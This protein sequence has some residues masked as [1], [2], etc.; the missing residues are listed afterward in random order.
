MIFIE[1]IILLLLLHQQH[2]ALTSGYTLL[3]HHNPPDHSLLTDKAALLAFKKTIIHDPNS[4]LDNWDEAVDVC[5]FTKVRCDKHHHHVVRLI[6]NE[7][8]LVGLL[9][10]FLSNLTRLR[11]LVFIGNHLFG[12]IPPEFS[13]LRHLQLLRIEGNNLQGTIPESLAL[14]SQL[15]TL[16]IKQNNISGTI[17]PSIFSNCTMLGNIDFSNNNLTGNIPEEIGNCRVLWNLNLY[18]NKFTGQLPFSLTN[19]SSFMYNIDVENNLLTGELPSKIVGKLPGLELLHLS[20]NWMESTN[21][22]P[23]FIALRNCTSLV[24]LELAGMH[25]GG[26]FPIS[27]GQLSTYLETLLLQENQLFGSIP[28]NVANLSNLLVLNLTSNLLNGT[29]PAEISQLSSLQQLFLSHNLFTSEIPTALGKF[30]HL[31][32]LDLSHNKFS[33]EIPAILGN[34]VQINYLFLN[35]NLLSGMIPPTLGHCTDLN[36]L[37]LSYNRLTGSIPPELAGIREIRIFINLSHNH[38][39]GPLPIELSKLENVQEMDLSSNKLT[40]SIF[41]QISSCIALR[42]INF[43]NNSLEG[44]LP[45]SLGELKN[46]ESFDVSGNRLS[47]MIPIS[48]NK[49][50]SLTYLNLSLNDFEGMI[51]TGGIFDSLSN[52]SFL[53]NHRLCK[54]INS[55]VAGIPICSHKRRWFHSPVFLIIFIVVIFI[56]VFLLTICCVIGFRRVRLIIQSQQTQTVRKPTTPEPLHNIP[57]MTHKELSDATAGFDEQR[58]VGSGGYGRVYRGVLPDAL[59]SDFGIARLVMTAGGGN[60]AAAEM[61]NSTANMLRGSIGYIAPGL[62]MMTRKRPTDD[63]FSGGLSLH[64]WVKSHYHGRVE[65]VIDPSL[66]RA[67]RDQSPE[68]KKMW[69]VAIGELMELGIL[70]TQESPST[71]PTMLDAADDLGRLKRYLSGDTTVTFASSLGISSSTLGDD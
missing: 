55:S 48:L 37:D 58:L 38:L 12:N 53:E 59:V 24:E 66:V 3:G 52:M 65:R 29:I 32:L 30:P 27:I 50:H 17:P 67:C 64:K 5:N 47:G 11:I 41:L 70:C 36:K 51:P 57:R 39:E 69:E 21:L 25:L 71:R 46:I 13:S 6:L 43:S 10:P 33:G 2:L 68:V 9:S 34:L 20:Y 61:G 7:T 15:T 31:G 28:P 40:G 8:Q 19:A 35:N 42:M 60:G 56:S 45:E 4:T 54:P 62:E 1:S 22:D 16:N 18:D 49:I 14:L 26:R 23:F 63:M 44:H